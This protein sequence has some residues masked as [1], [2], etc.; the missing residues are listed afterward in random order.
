M[1]ENWPAR[2]W[3]RKSW[4][5][6]LVNIPDPPKRLRIRGAMP[7]DFFRLC[8]VGPRKYTSYGEL[9][10]KKLISGLK[11]YPIS[12]ISGLAHGIDSIAHET[13]LEN[14]L[15]VIALP[16]SG[17]S[18]KA[19]YPRT[20][21]NFAHKILESGGCLI[22]EYD[23]EFLATNWSFP[24]RNR[25]MVGLAKATLIIEAREKSGTMITAKLTADYNRDM[26]TVPGSI[27]SENS[28]GANSLIKDGAQ[29]IQSVTD[30]IDFLGL[31]KAASG[32]DSADPSA[33]LTGLSA[34]EKK[35]FLQIDG[36][37]NTETLLAKN[38]MAV[39]TLN[40]I[41][42]SLEIQGLISVAGGQ[43][44]KK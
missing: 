29:V 11:G 16:G 36:M 23:D 35:I 1:E 9:V 32:V 41:L 17:L 40:I 28:I 37:T 5:E 39:E 2:A 6:E 21:L 12:I 44:C 25:L 26:L 34:G 42:S 43:I 33:D 14:H 22:S 4:P 8:V 19:I 24:R 10:C 30:I 7:P 31:K 27:L 18:D 13:A 3:P 20:R 15:H 38:N